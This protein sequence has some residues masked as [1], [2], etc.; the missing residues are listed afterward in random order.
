MSSTADWIERALESEKEVEKLNKQVANLHKFLD[1]VWST[2]KLNEA[3]RRR[4]LAA[5]A[6]RWQDALLNI[7][8]TEADREL[9]ASGSTAYE[10]RKCS[11]TDEHTEL[12]SKEEHYDTHWG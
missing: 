7:E 5:K 3:F 9:I 4:I 8:L 2:Y 10:N 6:E 1:E 11:P 12:L